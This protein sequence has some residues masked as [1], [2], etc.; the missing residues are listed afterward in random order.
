MPDRASKE[1]R[2]TV[3][4]ALGGVLG[5]A[6]GFVNVR[7]GDLLLTALLVLAFTMA[8]GFLRVEKPWRWTLLV[9]I[10]VPIA[11]LVA[12]QA[13]SQKPYRGQIY[14]AFLAFLPGVVG[15]YGGSLMRKVVHNLTAQ[16]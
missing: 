8:L 5:V 2:D 12:Y 14:G 13:M 16:Q 3:F 7:I 11:Q 6:A 1:K 10:F 9:A 15:A 4:Y